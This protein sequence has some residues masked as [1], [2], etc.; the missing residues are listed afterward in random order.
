MDESYKRHSRT[1]RALLDRDTGT[2]FFTDHVII[3]PPAEGSALQ[4][5]QRIAAVAARAKKGAECARGGTLV[6]FSEA[7]GR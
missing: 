3:P 4:V 5:E 6:V 2:V 1:R 7:V